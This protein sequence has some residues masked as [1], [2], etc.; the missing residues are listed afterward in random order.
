MN[1]DTL[2]NQWRARGR[3]RR[4]FLQIGGGVAG[5]IMLGAMPAR[6]AD[7]ALRT[8]AYPF[9]LGVASGDPTPDGVVLWTRLAPDPLGGGGM[10]PERAAVRWE[11][12][13]DEGF[14]RIVQR[15]DVLAVPELAHAV[16][17]EVEGLEPDRVYWYRFISGGEASPVGRTRT[18]PAAA[19][20][21]DRFALAFASCQHYETGYFTAHRHLAEEDL[22][23]VVFLG[24]YIYEGGVNERGVRQ[25]TGPEI[26]TLADYRNRYALYKTDPDLQAAH[27]AF[28]WTVT[29]DDHE[30]ENNYAAG[31]A[32]ANDP[33]EQF[34][35]RRAAAYQ[36]YYEHMPLRRAFMPKGPDLRLYRRLRFG[37]LLEVSMLDTRQYR[38]DQPC[39][40]RVTPPCVQTYANE[41]TILGAEQE[42]WLFDGL[43]RST[44][45][46]KL[47]GN[48]LPMAEVDRAAGPER[49][50]QMDQW[51]GYVQSRDRLMNFLHERRVSNSV[52]VTGDVHR[53]WVA[54]LQL[55]PTKLSSPTVATEFVGTSVTSGGDGREM[56]AEGE[57]I[58]ADNPH[59]K[60]Y[61]DQ[62]GYVRCTLTPERWQSDYRVLPYITRRGAPARTHASF[63]VE[64]GKPEVQRA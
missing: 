16:H 10:P 45:R 33:V 50:Y 9:S 14:G 5:L 35:Q 8:R 36:A 48:Q 30:V 58:L 63:V 34:L 43:G 19:S 13:S 64:D 28:A 6:R 4:E 17:V 31:I 53:S 22:N 57:S 21:P 51:S 32:Q 40:D 7:A 24:D 61:N 41:A 26:T 47:L 37:D 27:A 56:N 29:W 2:L 1:E 25:H 23:L 18:A 42:R 44:A 52:V 59:V 39:G 12:A 60:Y 15:G 20:R 49:A 11:I 3:T 62:R 54:E 38:T 55:D 46:W